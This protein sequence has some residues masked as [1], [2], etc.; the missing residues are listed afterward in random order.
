MEEAGGGRVVHGGGL[1]RGDQGDG[2]GVVLAVAVGRV[3]AG[4]VLIGGFQELVLKAREVAVVR[5]G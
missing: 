4:L 1:G 3:E 5:R 2:G